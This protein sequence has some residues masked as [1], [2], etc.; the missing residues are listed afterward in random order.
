[1][2]AFNYGELGF[3]QGAPP[4]WADANDYF[5]AG[6]WSSTLIRGARLADVPTP[7]THDLLWEVSGD[8]G[9]LLVHCL[10]T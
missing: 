8:H 1:M 6:R 10:V 5:V 3:R 7:G 2:E 4:N 9:D